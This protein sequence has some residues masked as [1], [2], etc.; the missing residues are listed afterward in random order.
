MAQIFEFTGKS[1]AWGI[2]ANT[3]TSN[4]LGYYVC[5]GP[6]DPVGQE[7]NSNQQFS[8]NFTG[9]PGSAAGIYYALVF[10]LGKWGYNVEK[11]DEWI[12]VSPTHREYYER[13]MAQ[14][15]ALEGT[16]RTGL[17]T[18]AAAVGDYELIAHDIRKYQEVLGYFHTKDDHSLKT[19]FIDQVDM[20]TG[21]SALNGPMRQRWPTVIADFIRL[22]D[23][24]V[25]P[26]DIAKKYNVSKPEGVILATKNKLYLDWK[27]TFLDAAKSRYEMLSGLVNS[28]K[29]VIEEY[30]DWLRPY[31]AR[32]KTIKLGTSSEMGRTAVFKSFADITGMSTFANGIKIYAW[33]FF[34]P[35]EIRKAAYEFKGNNFVYE[36]YD[37]Y[38]RNRYVVN[39]QSGLA[40]G[41]PWLLD[42]RKFC[43]RCKKYYS[44]G[45]IKCEKCGTTNLEDRYR[46]D[47]IVDNEIKPQWLAKSRGLRPEDPYYIFFDI[48]I[49]RY[50][51][52]LPV[53]EIEDITFNIKTFIISQNVMLV[54]LLELTCREK[55]FERYIDEMLGVKI[56]EE[57][58]NKVMR[59]EYP[60]I[61]G[62]EEKQSGWD[63]WLTGVKTSFAGAKKVAGKAKL[64]ITPPEKRSFMFIKPGPYEKNFT[65]RLAK[66]FLT[67]AAGMFEQIKG[68]LKDK[69]GVR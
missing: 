51:T 55:E 28:R 37:D 13:T 31:I 11:V 35:V 6:V 49:E 26:D 67:P 8:F 12:E 22:D 41:Y 39:S 57:D 14:K 24:D 36:P 7:E 38:M 1:S 52:K 27:V 62:E 46:A 69:A 40:R 15:Q 48:S 65:D 25:K 42:E 17:S 4:T 47:E 56:N 63:Q 23:K 5:V 9:P 29:K 21:D 30:R 50:G 60:G 18:A 54:K 10:Q 66:Q 19:M 61:F 32:F 44:E 3:P 68:F 2:Q 64:P 43:N 20:H 16:I 58:V 45:T 53:G 34:K 59:R 33:K